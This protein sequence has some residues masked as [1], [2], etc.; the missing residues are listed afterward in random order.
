MLWYFFALLETLLEL[1]EEAEIVTK[2][3]ILGRIKVFEESR[4]NHASK[5]GNHNWCYRCLGDN[6]VLFA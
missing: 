1:L 6:N 5:L 3:Q 2:E 4:V